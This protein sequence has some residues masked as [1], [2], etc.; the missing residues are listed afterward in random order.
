MHFSYDIHIRLTE[1]SR[2]DQEADLFLNYANLQ[3]IKHVKENMCPSF[4]DFALP[5]TSCASSHSFFR[6]Q[7]PKILIKMGFDV[8][9]RLR[10]ASIDTPWSTYI[11]RWNP[12]NTPKLYT[13]RFKN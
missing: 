5:F 8:S 9:E 7:T 1:S 4:L 12:E 2:H 3:Y 10:T 13:D 6:V 11:M